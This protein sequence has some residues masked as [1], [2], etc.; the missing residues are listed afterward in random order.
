MTKDEMAEVGL[1]EMFCEDVDF[2]L[3]LF[4]QT[5]KKSGLE[6]EPSL[7]KDQI[8]GIYQA[9]GTLLNAQIAAGRAK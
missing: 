7:T 4:S 8:I 3:E 9:A 5:M 6:F 2:L 1:S